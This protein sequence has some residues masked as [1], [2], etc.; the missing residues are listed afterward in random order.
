MIRWNKQ[1]LK[2]SFHSVL[3][4]SIG[5]LFVLIKISWLVIFSIRAVWGDIFY[6]FQNLDLILCVTVIQMSGFNSLILRLSSWKGTL[7]CVEPTGRSSSMTVL[8]KLWLSFFN[9][10]HVLCKGFCWN[11]ASKFP[12]LMMSATCSCKLTE[13]CY[14]LIFLTNRFKA[15]R[16]SSFGKCLKD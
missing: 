5:G 12:F 14:I 10:I 4:N 6:C 15:C 2:N 16:N 1:C 3:F 11:S 8:T 9:L 7:R 13:R